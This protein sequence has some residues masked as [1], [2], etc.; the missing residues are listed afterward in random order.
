MSLANARELLNAARAGGYALPAFNVNNLEFTQAVVGAAGEEGAPVIVE[1]SESALA[2]GGEALARLAL[3]LIESAPVPVTLH[4]DH[5]K[6]LEVA[7]QAVAW[8]FNSVMLDGSALPYDDNVALVAAAVAEFGPAGIPVEAELGHVGGHGDESV[9]TEP[10]MAAAFMAATGATSLAVSVGTSHGAYK[11]KGEPRLELARLEAIAG[12]TRA[13]LVLHGASAVYAD[14][15]AAL[16]A[17]GGELPGARGLP[18]EL[19]AEAVRRGI[20]KV[21]VDTDLRIAFITAI[22]AF[23]RDEAGAIDPKRLLGA[24]RDAVGVMARRKITACGTRGRAK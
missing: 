5:G 17:A 16:T 15:A 6:K 3:E 19:L 7:R 12:A 24:G 13:P 11:F 22:R 1:V 4:L 8:G 2:Y 9:Y 14:A 20:A 21:N 18:D 23:L 10:D